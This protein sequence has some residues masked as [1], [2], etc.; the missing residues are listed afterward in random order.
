MHAPVI[1]TILAFGAV[2]GV[3]IGASELTWPY[4]T[5]SDVLATSGG[6]IMYES[7]VASLVV[8]FAVRGPVGQH[9]RV[10]ALGVLAP[11]FPLP[12]GTPFLLS[13]VTT[14]PGACALHCAWAVATAVAV[15]S[16]PAESRSAAT[17]LAVTT[18]ILYCGGQLAGRAWM[19]AAGCAAEWALLFSPALYL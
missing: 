2:A 10:G 9:A 11:L 5:I 4:V 1:R 14:A 8:Y 16:G 13:H 19:V 17:V 6:V 3:I 12:Y 18:V 15:C 7:W